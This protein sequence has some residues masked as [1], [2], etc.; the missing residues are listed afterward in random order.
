MGLIHELGAGIMLTL[1]LLIAALTIFIAL[2]LG[3]Q[4]KRMRQSLP[5]GKRARADAELRVRLREEGFSKYEA[6]DAIETAR[7]HDDV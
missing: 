5:R 2:G 3:R 4:Y 1:G 7:S 6:E